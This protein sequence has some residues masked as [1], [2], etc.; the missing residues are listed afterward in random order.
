MVAV[1]RFFHKIL[2]SIDD[3]AF[4]YWLDTGGQAYAIKSVVENLIPLQC[5]GRSVCYFHAGSLSVEYPV[6]SD[7]RM[8][9][10]ADQDA[11]LS[12]AEYVVVFQ[13]TPA[14]VEDAYASVSSVVNLIVPQLRVSLRLYPNPGH[15]VVEDLVMFDDAQASAVDKNSAVVTAPYLIALDQR[16]ASGSDLNTRVQVIK[17]VVILQGS[18]SIVVEIDTNLFAAVDSI[19]T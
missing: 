6:V 12:I 2:I 8:A 5:R 3:V 19:M 7:R 17:D 18:M 1:E 4:K 13:K 16:V 15:C 14:I 11:R 9:V 10:V